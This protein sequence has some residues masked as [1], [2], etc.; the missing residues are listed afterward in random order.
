MKNVLVKRQ[1]V[2]KIENLLVDQHKPE[3]CELAVRSTQVGM[4]RTHPHGNTILWEISSN[5]EFSETTTARMH[6]PSKA[7]RGNLVYLRN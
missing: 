4:M 2:E 5:S 6:Y 7:S 3:C 1:D